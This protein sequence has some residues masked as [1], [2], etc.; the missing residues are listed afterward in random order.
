VIALALAREARLQMKE[1]AMAIGKEDME[2]ARGKRAYRNVSLAKLGSKGYRRGHAALK[3]ASTITVT[4]TRSGLLRAA[5]M[6]DSGPNLKRLP[7]A[8]QRLTQ[9]VRVGGQ[10]VAPVLHSWEPLPHG[11]RLQVNAAWVP[12]ARYCMVPWPPPSHAGGTITLALYLFA[13]GT[14]SKFPLPVRTLTTRLHIKVGYASQVRRAIA[15][16][17]KLANAHLEEIGA[18]V[19]LVPTWSRKGSTVKLERKSTRRGYDAEEYFTAAEETRPAKPEVPSEELYDG[20]LECELAADEARMKRERQREQQAMIEEA[21]NAR[22]NAEVRAQLQR[23]RKALGAVDLL[24]PDDPTLPDP[25][26]MGRWLKQKL[27]A[28]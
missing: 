1:A 18:P 28:P 7:A 2:Q 19:Q 25:E 22:S 8:L 21:E 20:P 9:P 11:L 27:G 10:Q 3:A 26:H 14:A 5:G 12:Q 23:I 17:L 13:F 24:A 6:R 16:A 4:V 15:H